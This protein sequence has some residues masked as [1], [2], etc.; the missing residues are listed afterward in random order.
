MFD[1]YPLLKPVL[2]RID[3]EQAHHLTLKLLK[4]GLFP[5][6]KTFQSSMLET[7]VCGLTL[8]N[9]IGLSAGFDKN[10]E[11][12]G[13]ALHMGFGFVEAGTVTPKPQH[14]NPKPRIFRDPTTGSVINR[15]GFPN[16]G[17]NVFKDN[18]ERYFSRKERG[19]GV[20][21]I[22]IGMNKSQTDPAKDYT[23][24]V[25]KLGP[26]ADYLTVNI[27]S[28]NT[29]G[30]RNL[31]KADVFLE[32]IGTVLEARDA[33]CGKLHPPPLFVKLAPDLDEQQQE[34]LAHAALQSGIDGL[35]L[36]NTTLA[37]PEHLPESFRNE[38]GGL[39]GK[40][41]T[42]RSTQVIR[43]FYRLTGGKLPIIGVGGV[44]SGEDAYEKIRAG[45]SLVQLYS[46]LVFQGPL[47]VSY[48]NQKLEELLIRD[49]YSHIS[50][51]VGVDVDLKSEQHG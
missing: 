51:A 10:A 41:L 19:R 14:G 37:R 43:N 24:L 5:R 34:E 28:P 1:P 4:S 27:S 47:M 21:G 48:V 35:I 26:M 6:Q 9:P 45:A 36:S 3:P 33:A 20:V 12:I 42:Q 18:L 30:L 16:A 8:P 29:P 32:L 46:S 7:Q 40:P 44:S 13:P 23:V 50:E 22:N 49:G 38:A 25:H 17:M 2:F 15:M 11:V 39:S 31:Q